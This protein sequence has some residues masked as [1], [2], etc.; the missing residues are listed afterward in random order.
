MVTFAGTAE[1]EAAD[2]LTGLSIETNRIMLHKTAIHLFFL[3]HRFFPPYHLIFD[4]YREFMIIVYNK[5]YVLSL[6]YV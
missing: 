5:I 3:F 4:K 6:F 2:T 1:L